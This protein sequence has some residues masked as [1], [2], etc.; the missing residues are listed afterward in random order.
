LEHEADVHVVDVQD[1]PDS[2][3]DQIAASRCCLSTSL[4]GIVVAQA[5][6]VP[7]VWLRV[8]QAHLLGGD[9]KFED[10]FTVVDR[11]S[12]RI[13]T[14]EPAS[15]TAARLRA[16]AD[17]ARLPRNKMSFNSLLDSFPYHVH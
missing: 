7:W 9:F 14:I 2:V 1:N 13:A 12:V 3:V 15:V 8:G 5:Y 10:F 6:Q 17:F 4:H 16:L 11:A